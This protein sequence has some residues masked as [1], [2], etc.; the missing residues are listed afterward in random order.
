MNE[1][2]LLII[3]TLFVII[4]YITHDKKFGILANFTII[5]FGITPFYFKMGHL[6]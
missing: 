4:E 5:L 1:I 2:I 6:F 3:Y